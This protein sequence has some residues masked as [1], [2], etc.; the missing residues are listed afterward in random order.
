GLG[1]HV[2]PHEPAL[3]DRDGCHRQRVTEHRHR[4]AQPPER[5]AH[6]GERVAVASRR[7]LLGGGC[8]FRRTHGTRS[9]LSSSQVSSL[10]TNC[11]RSR[12]AWFC[13]SSSLVLFATWLTNNNTTAP[14]SEP[15]RTAASATLPSAEALSCVKIGSSDSFDSAK[16]SWKFSVDTEFRASCCLSR[17]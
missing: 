7:A 16:L 5:T 4:R 12:L 8:R 2:P 10:R 9:T 17:L 13:G 15:S 14:E 1:E 6:S 11:S 3:R